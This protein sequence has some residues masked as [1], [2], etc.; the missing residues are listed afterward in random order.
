MRR[1]SMTK[2]KQT[3]NEYIKCVK[4]F[5]NHLVVYERGFNLHTYTH[6]HTARRLGNKC[7]NVLCMVKTEIFYALCTLYSD[8]Y[9]S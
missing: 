3:H 4:C 1:N 9:E 7:I 8:D 6:T 2:M 5:E